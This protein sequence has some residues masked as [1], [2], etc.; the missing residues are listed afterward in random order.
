MLDYEDIAYLFDRLNAVRSDL[1]TSRPSEKA[2]LR[3][4]IK[5]ITQK[6]IEKERES[7]E[8]ARKA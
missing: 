4:K 3:V 6:I 8:S 7:A 5:D 1:S 2:S